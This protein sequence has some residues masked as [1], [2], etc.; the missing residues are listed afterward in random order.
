MKRLLFLIL[1]IGSAVTKFACSSEKPER[2]SLH[3]ARV[4][5]KKLSTDCNYPFALMIDGKDCLYPVNWSN[6]ERLLDKDNAS[7][8]ITYREA[9]KVEGEC[10]NGKSIELS[11]IEP[12]P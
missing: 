11:Y 12:I 5:L 10:A 6:F 9:K 1:L 7:Y 4:T 8:N 2:S 3:I